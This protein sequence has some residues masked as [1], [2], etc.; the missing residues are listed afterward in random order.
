MGIF[1]D[2]KFDSI[3]GGD[4]GIPGDGGLSDLLGALLGMPDQRQHPNREDLTAFL[5]ANTPETNPEFHDLVHDIA[6]G[7]AKSTLSGPNELNLLPEERWACHCT[8]T[9]LIVSSLGLMGFTS[10]EAPLISMAVYLGYRLAMDVAHGKIQLP[11]F[12][13]T[14]SEEGPSR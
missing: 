3:F 6:D 11:E 9:R 1:D 2:G 13:V 14:G 10:G 5:K 8:G 12:P 4:K 7:W